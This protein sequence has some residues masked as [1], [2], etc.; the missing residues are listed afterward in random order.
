MRERARSQEPEARSQKAHG[1]PEMRASG[2]WL[3]ASGF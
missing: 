1:G 3:L 2:F